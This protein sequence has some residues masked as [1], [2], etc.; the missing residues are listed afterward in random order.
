METITEAAEGTLDLWLDARNERIKKHL[1]Y[2]FSE[3][4]ACPVCLWDGN[5]RRNIA[6]PHIEQWALAA[7]KHRWMCVFPLRYLK[8]RKE[9][10]QWMKA[11]IDGKL[12][13]P[14]PEASEASP[15]H[16]VRL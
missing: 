2:Q 16:A 8:H 10:P 14:D 9:I 5:R 1:E 13:S 15:A 12:I 11:L 4:F 6:D 3:L 7:V